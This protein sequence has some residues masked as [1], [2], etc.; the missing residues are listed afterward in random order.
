[1]QRILILGAR[2]ARAA[3]MRRGGLVA[4]SVS[5][6]AGVT[7]TPVVAWASTLLATAV[8]AADNATQ[9]TRIADPHT[10][11]A[12]LFENPA[13]LVQFTTPTYGAD[14]GIAYGH[15]HVEASAPAGYDETNNVWPAMPDFGVSIP[16]RERWRF[17]CGAYGTTGSTFNYG[18]DPSLGVP[19][20]LSETIVGSFPF[21]VAYR[22]TD[23]L[24]IGATVEPLFG[25][26]RSHFTASG[27]E[28]RYKLNGPGVQGAVGVSARPTDEWAV[29]VSARLP[30]MIWMTGTM[31]VPGLGRQDVD[32]DLQMPTQIFAG[33]TWRGVPRLALSAAM[34]FTDSSSF[35]DSTIKY[36]LT[37]QANV[38]FVPDAKNEW[39][40]A[41]AGEYALREQLLLRAGGSWASHIVGASG[42]NP[43]VYDADDARLSVGAGQTF[44]HWVFDVMGGYALP[45]QRH[46]SASE[47][48]VFPGKYSTYG[49]IV[50]VGL[51]YR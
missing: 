38:G 29:G 33:A 7:L 21:G 35:G 15:G 36:D 34:R 31:P 5:L 6:A 25:Q 46:I 48:L 1:M 9:G 41:L 39:K 22:L 49:V 10:P 3:M 2:C 20:F 11:A 16:Y 47:A 44:G 40:F 17:A 18:A 43:L 30:G 12:A 50:I 51:T 19:R 37:P 14:L 13:G 26:L 28:F 4:V 32:V 23:R 24:S 8:G 27:L 45:A 42:V